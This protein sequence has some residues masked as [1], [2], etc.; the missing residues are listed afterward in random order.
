MTHLLIIGIGAQFHLTIRNQA[1][2]IQTK[3]S[4][5]CLRIVD[6]VILI[7]GMK[8]PF[9]R[10]WIPDCPLEFIANMAGINDIFK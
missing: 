4:V 5:A 9:I 10:I 7:Q 1:G 6:G 3:A 8:N 2:T